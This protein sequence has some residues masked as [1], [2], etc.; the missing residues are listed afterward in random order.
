[1]ITLAGERPLPEVVGPYRMVAALGAGGMGA[2]HVAEHVASGERVALK[3]VRFAAE[4]SLA[5]IRREIHALGRVRH[6]GVVR[7]VADG[8]ADGMPWYAMELLRGETLRDRNRSLGAGA[9][10]PA[11][12]ATLTLYRRLCAPLGFL[13][14]QGFVHRDLTPANVFIREDG[15]PV[16]VDLGLAARFRGSGGRDVID[17]GGMLEGTFAYMAPEQIRGEL[18]DARADLYALGCLLYESL[19]GAPPFTGR[20]AAEVVDRHLNEPPASPSA[21]V[22][23]L[24]AALDALV[25]GLLAKRPRERIGYATEVAAALAALGA[26]DWEGGV[27]ARPR[28]YAYRPSLTGR[29][30]WLG[31]FDV[32]LR[33]LRRGE[34]GLLFL[35][36]E[37][38]V[39]KTR[40]ATE[41][42]TRARLAGA[43]VVTGEC[44]PVGVPDDAGLQVTAGPLHPFLPLLRAVADRCRRMGE[45][46]TER[47]LGPRGKVLAAY[48]P[49]LAGLPGQERYPE[50]AVLTGPGA[51]VR[52]LE[53]LRETLAAFAEGDPLV[54]VLDDVQWADDLS[55]AFLETLSAEF[56]AAR[57][58]LLVAAYRSEEAG[59]LLEGLAAAPGARRFEVHRLRHDTVAEMIGEMLAL[60]EPPREVVEFVAQASEG[61]PLF[62]TEYLQAAVDEGI[63]V[64]DGAGRWRQAENGGCA[65]GALPL[66]GTLQ[67]LLARRL[68]G[69]PQPA[70]G[71]LDGAACLGRE[72]AL[73]LLSAVVGVDEG[74]VM[75]GVRQL[76]QRHVLEEAPDGRLRFVHDKLREVAY[77]RIPVDRRVVLH[78]S[79]ALAIEARLDDGQPAARAYPVLAHHWSRAA[80]PDKAIEYLEKAG[81]SA[82]ASAAFREAADFFGRLL[83]TASAANGGAAVD[84]TRPARWRRRLAEA[85]WG[86]GD[87]AGCEAHLTAALESLGHGIP[88]SRA[89]WRVAI[90]TQSLRQVGHL[91]RGGRAR[92]RRP[93]LAAEAALAAALQSQRYYFRGEVLPMLSSA[94][95]AVNLAEEAGVEVR[96]AEIY[97]QLAYVAGVSRLPGLARRYFRRAVDNAIAT[98]DLQGLAGVRYREAAYHVGEGRWAEATVAGLRALELLERLANPQEIETVLAI[99]GHADSCTARFAQ[100][101]ERS[102]RLLVSARTRANALHEAWGLYTVG[103]NRLALGD[104]DAATGLLEQAWVLLAATSDRASQMICR[105]LLALASLRRG[106]LER[107]QVEADAASAIARGRLPTVFPTGHGYAAMAET[108][109]GLRERGVAGV[110][111]ARVWEACARLWAYAMVFPIGLPVALVLS[112]RANRLAGRRRLARGL[113]VRGLAAAQRLEMPYDEAMAHWELAQLRGADGRV[114]AEHLTAAK[115]RCAELGVTAL[116]WAAASAPLGEE[117]RVAS[118]ALAERRVLVLAAEDVAGLDTAPHAE[119]LGDPPER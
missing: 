21:A 19:T 43:M 104:P 91:V 60:A 56:L 99:L 11:L 97:A 59:P 27:E 107:A 9:A 18:V 81:E 115:R 89:G 8:V 53:H 111:R 13:H 68:A 52:L 30:E 34:G 5:S 20:S 46:E 4:G 69:V 50:G 92:G 62:V 55:L 114:R 74:D 48:E 1:M 16:V 14:G 42:A 76:V 75:A 10:G 113:A 41:L 51:R 101:R 87:L 80:V 93:A 77:E 119:V 49:A 24:P 12:V 110:A 67:D 39:G 70:A 72:L 102:E 31:A 32:V 100:N 3:R 22:R 15:N 6:P 57:R 79:A 112:A 88:R 71:F 33:R 40:L 44:A 63:L 58:M 105:G 37:S 84:A 61:V 38:G 7:I 78:R 96:V 109:L 86:L 25:L 98:D 66:P 106:D 108:Y 116:P 82:L 36:G 2:L 35:R 73:E 90:V 103:R 94:L 83:E 45:A 85:S 118:E 23:T 64:R 65:A 17:V 47:L 26:E 29:D 95:F 54:L 117:E 28:A